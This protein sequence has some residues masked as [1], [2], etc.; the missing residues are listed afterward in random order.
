MDNPL[1]KIFGNISRL[2]GNTEDSAVGIDIGSSAIKVVEIKKKGGRA[3]LETYGSIALGPY[4]NLDAGR[5]TNLS[6]EKIGTALKEVLKQ[7]GATVEGG[8][9]SIP[10][11]S[12]LIF[13]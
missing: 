13:T 12:S 1:K 5:V 3:L 2:V 9:F 4:D 10:V 7:S 8:A 11:Q 6:V